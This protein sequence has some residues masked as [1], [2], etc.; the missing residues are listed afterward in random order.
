MSRD[1]ATRDLR[2]YLKQRLDAGES[3][4]LLPAGAVTS[5]A[6]EAAGGSPPGTPAPEPTA[7]DAEVAADAFEAPATTTASVA[8]DSL[9]QVAAEIR[10]CTQCRLHQTR[11]NAVPGVG[12]DDAGLVFVGEGPGADEDAQ[13]EPFVGRAGQLLTK[14]IESVKLQRGEVFITNIVKCRPPNNRDPQPDEVAACEPYLRR[15]LALLQ[16]RVICALGRHASS[17]LLKTQDSMARLRQG[18]HEYAGIRVFPTY[19][20]AALLRNSKWKRPVWEDIQNVRRCYDTPE[21]K[22]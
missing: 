15:Q 6:A 11:T 13:G 5:S 17:A 12:P 1:E 4:V 20:P 16:P 10:A 22:P 8:S 2:R 19:H 18:R 7:P 14:I 3:V 9:A 21:Q